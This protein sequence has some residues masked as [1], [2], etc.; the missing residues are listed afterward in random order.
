MADETIGATH[1][2]R[3]IIQS[4][5]EHLTSS[6]FDLVKLSVGGNTAKAGH[7]VTVNG[8]TY[9]ILKWN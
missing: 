1:G 2:I 7:I 9:L 5:S 3:R 4:G 6:N 8:E